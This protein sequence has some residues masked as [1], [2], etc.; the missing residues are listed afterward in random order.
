MRKNYE[1]GNYG[2]G[3]AK[4]ALFELIIEQMKTE[5]ETFDHYMENREAL[6]QK[7]QE[8]EANAREIGHAVLARVKEKI[9]F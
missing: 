5:R 1:G 3:H 7:L 6:I 9:G 8:G 2:Y 4:Q